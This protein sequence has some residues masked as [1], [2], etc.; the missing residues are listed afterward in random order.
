MPSSEHFAEED[1]V[2]R[3][4]KAWG[5]DIHATNNRGF[6]AVHIAAWNGHLDVL[7]KLKLWNVDW[8]AS[9]KDGWNAVHCA[10]KEGHLDVVKVLK[11]WNVDLIHATDNAGRSC[12]TVQIVL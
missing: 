10:A 2:L 7:R 4:L 8:N 11:S 1:D 9:T 12:A 5:V 3:V 6:N